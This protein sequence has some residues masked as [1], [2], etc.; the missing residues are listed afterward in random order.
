MP[1]RFAYQVDTD[2]GY[3]PHISNPI[4]PRTAAESK[5]PIGGRVAD[6]KFSRKT[7]P[8]ITN[9]KIEKESNCC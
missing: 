8:I 7:P 3:I 1:L 2:A 9:R 6:Q 4:E 5:R